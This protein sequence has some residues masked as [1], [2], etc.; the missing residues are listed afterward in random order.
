MHDP[1]RKKKWTALHLA[2]HN[3]FDRT[4]INR[5]DS[6][7][8]LITKSGKSKH[9]FSTNK[10]TLICG[11][12]HSSIVRM[13]TTHSGKV[14]EVDSAKIALMTNNENGFWFMNKL[15]HTF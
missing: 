6:G 10:K 7:L 9:K 11:G 8:V 4:N 14:D 12:R 15:R 1:L 2:A 5:N 3:V 13:E